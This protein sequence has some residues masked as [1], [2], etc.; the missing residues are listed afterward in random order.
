MRRSA[1]TELMYQA[2]ELLIFLV[3]ILAV[4]GPESLEHRQ[5][6]FQVPWLLPRPLSFAAN[7]VARCRTA[8]IDCGAPLLGRAGRGEGGEPGVGA[9]VGCGAVCHSLPQLQK[10]PCSKAAV[11]RGAGRAC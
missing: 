3:H 4:L 6:H 11:R 1:T 2:L 7:D 5:S 8:A 10:E 9:G